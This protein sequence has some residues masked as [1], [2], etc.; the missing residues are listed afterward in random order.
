[1]YPVGHLYI[2][3]ITYYFSK[4]AEVTTL[5]EVKK[6]KI[7][8]NFYRTSIIYHFGVLRYIIIDNGKEFYNIAMNKL[9][10]QFGF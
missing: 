10:A 9:F 3:V 1:M 4:W 5:K 2:L 7:V 6:K 8:V